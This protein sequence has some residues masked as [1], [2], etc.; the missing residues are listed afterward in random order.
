MDRRHAVNMRH[1][2]RHSTNR[3]NARNDRR[4]SVLVLA[5]ALMVVIFGLLAFALDMGFIALTKSQM[6]GA[7]DAS[8]LAACTELSNGLGLQPALTVSQVIA[9]PRASASAVAGANPNGGLSATYLNGARDISFGQ[10]VWNPSSK[11]WEKNWGVSPYN[12]VRV[13]VHRDTA[14]SMESMLGDRPMDTF[15][16]G[17]LGVDH[18][19]LQTD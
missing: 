9:E 6:Q 10:A 12:M 18:V 1:N 17:S 13:T 15:F 14:A 3:F 4:G 19:S 16:A 2:G 11:Q 7:S 8:S 5:A